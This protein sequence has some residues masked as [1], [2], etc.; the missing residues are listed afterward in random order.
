MLDARAGS[1]GGA[2]SPDLECGGVLEAGGPALYGDLLGPSLHKSINHTHT[3]T[4]SPFLLSNGCELGLVTYDMGRVVMGA[5]GKPLPPISGLAS[6]DRPPVGDEGGLFLKAPM[7]R[8][9]N[10]VEVRRPICAD[11]GVDAN[12]ADDGVTCA[13]PN[14]VPAPDCGRCGSDCDYTEPGRLSASPSHLAPLTK[15]SYRSG[16]GEGGGTRREVRAARGTHRR[17]GGRGSHDLILIHGAP[18]LR[19]R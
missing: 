16:A 9:K 6:G 5:S 1:G 3:Q 13:E 2:T 19:C 12:T 10:P 17:C 11:M 4:P 15:G 7:R 14:M 18:R 8:S